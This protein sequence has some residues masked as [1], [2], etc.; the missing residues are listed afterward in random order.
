MITIIVNSQGVSG[1][2]QVPGQVGER[3]ARARH[4]HAA[5]R[6]ARARARGRARRL[7]AARVGRVLARCGADV[8]VWCF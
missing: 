1:D 6:R 2:G 7:V 5:G 4:A 3:G 8:H